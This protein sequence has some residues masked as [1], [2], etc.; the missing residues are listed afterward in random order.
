MIRQPG[1][2]WFPDACGDYNANGDNNSLTG[3]GGDDTY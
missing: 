1:A 2:G 3:A